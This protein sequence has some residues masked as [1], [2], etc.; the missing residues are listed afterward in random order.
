MSKKIKVSVKWMKASFKECDPRFIKNVCHGRCCEN[1]DGPAVVS[2]LPDEEHRIRK[3][4]IIV[5]HGIIK[6]QGRCPFKNQENL[7]IIH[8]DHQEPWGC[9]A[10]PFVINDNDTLVIRH[11]YIHFP[12]FKYKGS[13]PA[14]ISHRRALEVVVGKKNAVSICARMINNPSKDFYI[15]IHHNNYMKMVHKQR[16]SKGAKHEQRHDEA[17]S[18]A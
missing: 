9:K 17:E 2:I 8:A 5:K 3:H 4:D 18:G 15:T 10:S 13:R 7:C 11:R 12:C 6:T 14:Y 16:T 1:S